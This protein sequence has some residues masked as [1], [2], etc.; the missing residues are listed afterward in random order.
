VM[1]E[2]PTVT[3]ALPNQRSQQQLKRPFGRA[4]PSDS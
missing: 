1:W 3:Q 2:P 4:P